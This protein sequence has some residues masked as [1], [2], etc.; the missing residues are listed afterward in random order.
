[1]RTG[2]GFGADL[3]AAL[4]AGLEGHLTCISDQCCKL[5]LLNYVVNCPQ[6]N[7]CVEEVVRVRSPERLQGIRSY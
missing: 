5:S 4:T 6:E 7:L 3:V 2:L 1:M